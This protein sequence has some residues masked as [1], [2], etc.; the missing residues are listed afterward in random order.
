MQI[1]HTQDQNAIRAYCFD[2]LLNNMDK[3]SNAINKSVDAFLT[4]NDNVKPQIAKE[5]YN[6]IIDLVDGDI[7]CELKLGKEWIDKLQADSEYGAKYKQVIGKCEDSFNLFSKTLTSMK[8]APS[9]KEDLRLI[10]ALQRFFHIVG[11]SKEMDLL[12]IDEFNSVFDCHNAFISQLNHINQDLDEIKISYSTGGNE[13]KSYSANALYDSMLK[14]RALSTLCKAKFDEDFNNLYKDFPHLMID[15]N[16]ALAKLKDNMSGLGNT[17]ELYAN[18][19]SETQH[20]GLGDIG[21]LNS[22][23]NLYIALGGTHNMYSSHDDL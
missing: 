2:N 19:L 11:D 14:A 21:L 9:S 4:H 16:L 3:I 15:K 8:V 20:D 6:T 18:N 10:G 7:T 12:N 17:L 5:I 13:V 23:H 22:I 1:T